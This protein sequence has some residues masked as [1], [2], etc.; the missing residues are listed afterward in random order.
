MHT[1]S[2][3][4]EIEAKLLVPEASELHAIA[5]LR[6]IGPY[7]LAPR[8]SARLY[9][10]Y[11][12]TAD[13]ALAQRGVALRLRRRGRRWEATLKWGG[14][15]G[16]L[17]H[18]RSEINVPL[19]GRPSMPFSLPDGP[20]RRRLTRLVAGR[21]LRP[22]LITL[23]HRRRL[24]VLPPAPAKLAEPVAEL[25]LDTVR[26]LAPPRRERGDSRATKARALAYREV[27]V[28]LIGGTRR[29][30][31][32]L[33]AALQRDFGLTPSRQSKFARGLAMLYPELA[34]R[35]NGR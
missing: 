6:R 13:L 35:R 33:A 18:E 23:I 29:D 30:L 15:T 20:I 12:D 10:E 25:A 17:I 21:P 3:A 22:I 27:E 5:A 9:S 24:D 16:R 2:A 7:R 8:Q 4:L 11:L 32:R 1:R 34:P 14:K 28:E 31:T 19:P 26:L